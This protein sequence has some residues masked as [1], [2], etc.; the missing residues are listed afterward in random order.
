MKAD[1]QVYRGARVIDQSSRIFEIQGTLDKGTPERKEHIDQGMAYMNSIFFTK[2]DQSTPNTH[3]QKNLNF[4]RPI[5]MGARLRMCTL[6]NIHV[7]CNVCG[8]VS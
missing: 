1:F 5:T 2:Y 4:F 8:K 3:P 7:Y 6:I